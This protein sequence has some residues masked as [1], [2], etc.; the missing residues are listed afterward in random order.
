MGGI[1]RRLQCD[2]APDGVHV[3]A[4]FNTSDFNVTS[5][6]FFHAAYNY[7]VGSRRQ[8]P[9]AGR[10]KCLGN[11]WQGMSERVFRHADPAKTQADG[12]A[13]HAGPR[14]EHLVYETNAY[15]GNVFHDVAQLGVYEASGRWLETLD[16]FRSALQ[17]VGCLVD[18]LGVLDETPPLWRRGNRR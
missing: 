10:N 16:D 3:A 15:A 5:Q 1:D 11:V 4:Q 9:H 8:A 18:D 6:W 12:N 13:A 2:E 17:Q 7:T 14:K